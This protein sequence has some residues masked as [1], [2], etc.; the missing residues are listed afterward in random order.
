MNI[1]YATTQQELTEGSSISARTGGLLVDI[2]IYRIRHSHLFSKYA[3]LSQNVSKAIFLISQN[4]SH[5]MA[6]A[7]G[8]RQDKGRNRLF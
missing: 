7:T 8:H 4:L 1:C 3:S 5:N 6:T 2:D